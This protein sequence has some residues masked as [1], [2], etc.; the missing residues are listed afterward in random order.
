[1]EAHVR[2]IAALDKSIPC[3]PETNHK[4]RRIDDSIGQFDLALAH[5][6]RE[7][8]GHISVAEAYRK[9]SHP[10]GRDY[11]RLTIQNVLRMLQSVE[12]SIV[13][14]KDPEIP[15]VRLRP[16]K[17]AVFPGGVPSQ[18]GKPSALRKIHS[19]SPAIQLFELTTVLCERH[20]VARR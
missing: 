18:N 7:A 19:N 14:F 15:I 20:A 11:R 8:G 9:L 5:I 10:G 2:L 1:M 3:W 16:S 17:A 12:C 4:L 6:V 13:E